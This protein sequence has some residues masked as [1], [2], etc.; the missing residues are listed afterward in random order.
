M[1]W[2]PM[3]VRRKP[4][5]RQQIPLLRCTTR[6]YFAQRHVLMLHGSEPVPWHLELQGQERWH[7]RTRRTRQMLSAPSVQ[8]PPWSLPRRCRTPIVARIGRS[9]C[10]V[11]VLWW[12]LCVWHELLALPHAEHYCNG[13]GNGSAVRTAAAT[14]ESPAP[15]TETTVST[16]IAG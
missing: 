1:A 11:S 8:L 15:V 10:W 5:Y 3:Q 2:S 9:S 7:L 4:T 16:G 12:V 6:L 14:K 13:V